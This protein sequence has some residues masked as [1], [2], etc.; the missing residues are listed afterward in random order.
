MTTAAETPA[1]VSRRQ[2]PLMAAGTMLSRLTGFAR[3]AA[4]VAALGVSRVGDAYNT[5]NTL[6]NVLFYL[7]T[8][9]TVTAVL[10]TLL[11]QAPDQAERRRRAEV[12]GGAILALT[13]L[14]SLAVLGLSP[15]IMRL[16]AIELRG[17]PDYA[18]YL[19]VASQWLMLFAPQILCYGLSTYATALLAARGRLA[20]AGFAP[21]ATNLITIAGAA[22][23]A[24]TGGGGQ[25]GEVGA[26]PLVALG[27]ATTLGVAAMAA[28]Q[29]AGARRVL[30]GPR[31]RLR[32][33]LHRRD[34]ALREL[35][36]LGRWTF[37]YVAVNQLGLLVVIALATPTGGAVTAYQTAFMIMQLPFAIVAV[38]IFSALAPRLATAAKDDAAGF[39]AAFSTGFRLSTALLLPAA[40]GLVCL[41]QPITRLLIGYGQVSGQGTE[42]VAVALRWFGVALVPFTVF[43]LLTRGY[44]SLPDART[45]ALANIAV[46]A[47]NIGGAVG[48]LALVSGDEQRV[49]GLVVAYGLSYVT[50]VALLGG[51]LARH[52]PGLWRGAVRALATAGVAGGTMAAALLGLQRLWP[53]PDTMAAANLRTLLLVAAG[54]ITYLTVALLAR[55]REFAEL[56][57]HGLRS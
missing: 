26:V 45:P 55:S 34:P 13:G 49:A 10:V 18:A 38:S 37:L 27:A 44:Y 17:S 51:L 36:R 46:N 32:P 20:L 50:G 43:Q 57:A 28:I 2:A 3:T 23:Y 30:G 24:A 5:A 7:V 29:L 25:L 14:T 6:P 41:A 31:L 15:L 42:L 33:R 22:A 16:Y 39:A 53:V 40:I 21:V 19:R 56:R 12:I 54:G 1:L 48:L 4:V 8:G 47:V 35:L 9:G 52:R 11:A